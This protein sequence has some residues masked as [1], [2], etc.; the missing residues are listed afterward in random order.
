MVSQL[1]FDAGTIPEPIGKQTHT[2][3]TCKQQTKQT[4]GAYINKLAHHPPPSEPW[5]VVMAGT[6][7]SFSTCYVH[8]HHTYTYCIVHTTLATITILNRCCLAIIALS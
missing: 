2:Q 5:G 8:P 4:T 6:V 7:S 1:T 3:Y